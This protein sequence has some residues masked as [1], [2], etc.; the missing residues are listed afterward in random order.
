MYGPLSDDHRSL[1]VPDRATLR[2]LGELARASAV[3]GPDEAIA[4]VLDWRQTRSEHPGSGAVLVLTEA[5]RARW[6]LGVAPA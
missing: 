3:G 5:F 6:A 2:A 4:E 1:V